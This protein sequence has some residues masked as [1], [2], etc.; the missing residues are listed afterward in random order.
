M[1]GTAADDIFGTRGESTTFQPAATGISTAIVV[2]KANQLTN[3]VNV[4][5]KI[6]L[7]VID[8]SV[9][10]AKQFQQRLLVISITETIAEHDSGCT[11]REERHANSDFLVFVD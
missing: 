9:I 1:D 2:A 5:S 6:F 11:I 10:P 7:C 3:G 8:N 4:K